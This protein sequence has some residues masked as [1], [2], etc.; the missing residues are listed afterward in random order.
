MRTVAE[1][2]CSMVRRTERD[3]ICLRYRKRGRNRRMGC[4]CSSPSSPRIMPSRPCKHP[5]CPNYVSPP[6]KFCEIHKGERPPRAAQHSYYDEHFRNQQSKQFYN[7]A[8]W[9]RARQIALTSQP[10]CT[11]CGQLADTVHHKVPVTEA[12]SMQKID[13]R[14][15]EP[16]CAPCHS[17]LHKEAGGNSEVSRDG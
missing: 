2:L 9:K 10:W 5:A 16:L 8:E 14:F 15:L 4:E 12:T 1:E 11:R 13:Q 17:L 7:S 6:L 3:S